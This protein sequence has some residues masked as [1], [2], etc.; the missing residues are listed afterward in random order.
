MSS[1]VFVLQKDGSLVEMTQQDYDSEDIIQ[2][3]LVKHPDL[4]AG[5]LIDELNPRKWI[6]ISR[7]FSIPDQESSLGRWSLDHLFLDQDGI[8]TLVE[9]KRSSDTRIRRE[10]VGQMLEYAANA[11]SYW[12]IAKIQF[13]YE[14]RCENQGKDPE[15]EWK[16]RFQSDI[17]YDDYWLQVKTNIET[18]RIRMLF[19]ADIIP[20]ELKQIVEFL[21]VQMD[22]AEVLALE[23]KQ[24]IGDNQ[25][26]LI[27]RIFGQTVKTQLKKTSAAKMSK[28]WDEHSFLKEI[29]ER[30]GKDALLTSK[31]IM[32][33]GKKR[34][35]R[36]WYGKGGRSGSY[37]LML[38]HKD[39]S[40]WTFS[41]WTYGQVEIQFQHMKKRP[42][43]KEDEKRG[44]LLKKINEIP[45]V[46]IAAE[47]INSRP[48]L[49]IQSLA[50]DSA[51]DM[52][53][54]IWDTYLNTIRKT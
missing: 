38:D 54:R 35:L 43:Y 39:E 13:V 4:L 3:L 24:F 49:P 50:N 10:V 8:P 16:D 12:D 27:P 20:I 5:S 6:L 44:Q 22:P 52:F 29:E 15:K 25:R 31:K 51:I 41:I 53:L 23:I 17:E 30:L 2:E 11:V 9:V 45:G 21:N 7:E 34:N 47:K 26:T 18:G 14:S 36:P 40:Y 1:G 19:I 33:W 48:S 46:R 37:F 42:I 32:E 28:Q